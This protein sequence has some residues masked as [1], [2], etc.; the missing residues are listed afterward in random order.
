MPQ[1]P[2]AVLLDV[3]GTLVDSAAAVYDDCRD[4]LRRLERSPIAAL[5]GAR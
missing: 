2:A 5:L 1:T 3:D 4:L